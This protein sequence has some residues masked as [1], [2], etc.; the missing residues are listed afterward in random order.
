MKSF[1]GIAIPNPCHEN[2]EEM[3]KVDKG[4]FCSKCAKTVIDF[5]KMPQQ[6]ISNYLS[7]KR[8][9]K[10]CGR[11]T[12]DQLDQITIEIPT[13]VF[14]KTYSFRK[15]FM[16]LLLIVMGGTFFSCE[17]VTN[18]NSML[19]KVIVTDT[20]TKTDST[21]VNPIQI[22]TTSTV[23]IGESII[24]DSV[25]CTT[26]SA[27]KTLEIPEIVTTGEVVEVALMGDVEY[28]DPT[29][30]EFNITSVDKVP[31]FMDTNTSQNANTTATKLFIENIQQV[32]D[33]HLN[34]ELLQRIF[35]DSNTTHQRVYAEFIVDTLGY[36]SLKQVRTNNPLLQDYTNKFCE[37][38]PRVVPG[39]H[40][41]KKVAVNFACPF[42]LTREKL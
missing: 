6:E 18:N 15:S 27:K 24:N 9:E 40:N 8:G 33:K 12:N 23:K 25:K 5:T 28:V 20:I 34:K 31:E 17:T 19:G 26:E 4:K 11:F 22:D 38:L 37:F 2:W 3:S 13:E 21:T 7:N 10:I 32:Y 42:I 14:Y 35:K 16:L 30:T 41:H 36:I 29:L 1:S 39:E